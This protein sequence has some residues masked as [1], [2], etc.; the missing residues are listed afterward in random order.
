M[1]KKQLYQRHPC[2]PLRGKVYDSF[3]PFV[4]HF[5]TSFVLLAQTMNR[6]RTEH[7]FSDD[8][9]THI[10]LSRSSTLS[11]SIIHLSSQL[12]T[13]RDFE[14][15][16]RNVQP[17]YFFC[18]CWQCCSSSN[19]TNLWQMLP[20]PE[21]ASWSGLFLVSSLRSVLQQLLIVL[22]EGRRVRCAIG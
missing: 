11:L 13:N 10:D 3:M 5:H 17:H 9:Q 6:C 7:F 18:F 15:R 4:C 14:T 8:Q 12:T 19:C 20:I 21:M 22:Y 16:Q 2:S 1:T